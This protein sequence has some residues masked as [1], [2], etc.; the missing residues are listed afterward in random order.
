MLPITYRRMARRTATRF[1]WSLPLSTAVLPIILVSPLLLSAARPPAVD[2]I[3]ATCRL[4]ES[5]TIN[6]PQEVGANVVHRTGEARSQRETDSPTRSASAFVRDR[7]NAARQLIR[8][9]PYFQNS[10]P[11]EQAQAEALCLAQLEA[12]SEVL[13]AQA[14]LSA[15]PLDMTPLDD[16]GDSGDS[17]ELPDL[18]S[19]SGRP[20]PSVPVPASVPAVPRPPASP[21]PSVQ[22]TSPM[23]RVQTDSPQTGSTQT[24]STQTLPASNAQSDRPLATPAVD[25]AN[26]P[27]A[28]DPS[29]YMGPEFE[30]TPFDGT[31][32]RTL[33]DMPDGNYRYMAG[34]A[35][36]RA[37]S[38]EELR[39][40]GGSVF[41]LKKVGDRVTGDLL[42]RIGLPGICVT[43]TVSGDIITGAAYPYDT[44]DTLQDSARQIGETYEPHGSGALQI[45]RTRT[46]G[47]QLYYAGALLD[48]TTSTPINAGSSLPPSSCQVG[49]TGGRDRG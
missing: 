16:S 47:N 4:E 10:T 31:V 17:L 29:I 1:S 44:T 43:G 39:Q 15:Q 25:P 8:E 9:N 46:D 6:Q 36:K 28:S 27:T 12:D 45:R 37:Y 42:P 38:N 34:D 24:G 33:Q 23:P 41:V 35:E 20:A 48:L 40:R 11:T 2:S 32:V 14:A 26:L 19:P 30:P 18:S 7:W 21:A 22:P 5:E 13:L 3:S 49:R